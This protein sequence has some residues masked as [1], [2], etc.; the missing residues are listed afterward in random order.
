[1]NKLQASEA[2]KWAKAAGLAG[3]RVSRLRGMPGYR[4]TVTN[5]RQGG[6]LHSESLGDLKAWTQRWMP[7]AE[8][9]HTA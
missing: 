6:E 4:L 3:V 5:P 7:D 1:M 8:M 9:A 2:A